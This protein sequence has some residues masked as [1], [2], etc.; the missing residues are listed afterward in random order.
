LSILLLILALGVSMIMSLSA[1]ED[2][3]GRRAKGARV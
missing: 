2:R 1:R 3:P